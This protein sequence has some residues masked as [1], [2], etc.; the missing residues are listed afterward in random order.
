MN[1][2]TVNTEFNG[3]KVARAPV[4]KRLLSYVIDYIFILSVCAFIVSIIANDKLQEYNELSQKK[5]TEIT[6]EIDIE[7][8]VDGKRAVTASKEEEDKE[9]EEKQKEIIR[10]LAESKEVKF[11]I[12][13]VTIGYYMGF[14]LSRQQATPG[15]RLL[16]LM[17]VRFDGKRMTFTDT[18]NRVSLLF[19]FNI[20]A[21]VCLFTRDNLAVHDY[22]SKTM[23]IEIK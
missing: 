20:L 15:Q 3:Y 14:T 2:F 8:A 6:T 23:V 12:F 21:V 18:L 9:I 17:T 16:N 7:V 19:I 11:C 5:R 4:Q 1:N 10:N 13:F 22:L